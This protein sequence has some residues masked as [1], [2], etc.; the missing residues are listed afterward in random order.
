[1]ISWKMEEVGKK[2]YRQ[3]L[4]RGIT[5]DF[6][7][8]PRLAISGPNGSGKSTLLRILAGQ[9]T[10]SEGQIKMN[11]LGKPVLAATWYQYLSWA[12]PYISLYPIL[13]LEEAIKLHFSLKTCRLADPMALIELLGLTAHRHKKL[14]YYSSGMYQR[15][16]VGLAIVTDT[17][18]L[19]LDE[20][21]SNLD[22]QQAQRVYQLL[23]DHTAQRITIVASNLSRDL[24]GFDAV[25][26]LNR[27]R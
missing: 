2:F 1:M 20:P 11:H 18:I 22:S 23:A 5:H 3:W 14:Q 10:P 13:T 19:M 24:A 9:M 25:I 12:A 21:T 26:D 17:P 6:T 27:T 16:G 4:F 8:A 7:Q 15:V